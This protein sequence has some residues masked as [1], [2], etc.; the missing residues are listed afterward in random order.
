MLVLNTASH[1][2]LN[3]KVVQNTS[4]YTLVYLFINKILCQQVHYIALYYVSEPYILTTKEPAGPT[5]VVFD[6]Q[7]YNAKKCTTLELHY[8]IFYYFCIRFL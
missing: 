3:K 6:S 1:S 2:I 4:A 7:G 5:K 8:I